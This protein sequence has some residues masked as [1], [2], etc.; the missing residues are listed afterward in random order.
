MVNAII[1]PRSRRGFQR[2]PSGC[3]E[4]VKFRE[5]SGYAARDET[6]KLPLAAENHG[7]EEKAPGGAW[8]DAY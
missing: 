8:G 2:Q 4:S 5:Q 6:R 1:G 7:G 3:F